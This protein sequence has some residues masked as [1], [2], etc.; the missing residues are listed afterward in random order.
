M[1]NRFEK[2]ESAYNLSED[3]KPNFQTTDVAHE[4]FH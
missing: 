3:S 1:L 2:F 4:G